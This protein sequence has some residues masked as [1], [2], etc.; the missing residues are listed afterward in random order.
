MSLDQAELRAAEGSPEVDASDEA[1]P[2][3]GGRPRSRRR[4]RGRRRRG[5]RRVLYVAGAVV[6]AV[7]VWWVG[8]ASPVT[9]VQHVV[10]ETPQGISEKAVRKASGIAATDHVPAVDAARVR[11]NIMTALP[12]VAAVQ[13]N[14]SLPDTVTVTVTART[15]FAVIPRGTRYVVIDPAGVEFD[16]VGSAGKL[17]VIN[18]LS[19]DGGRA[20]LAVLTS[21]PAELR[22]DVRAVRASTHHNVDLTLAGGAT[23]R[24]GSPDEPELK[25]KVLAGLRSVKARHYDVSAPM[26]P[27]TSG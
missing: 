22:A 23:V 18:G 10:V 4:E 1:D 25:A 20:A 17:P 7:G 21:L 13:V 8:W 16:R 14:R 5:R 24:W 6:A 12:A 3:S 11:S 27:T 2:G 19:Y 26:M 15:P 9:L